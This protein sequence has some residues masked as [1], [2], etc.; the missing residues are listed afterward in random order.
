MQKGL[1]SEVF[2]SQE[3]FRA[4]LIAMANPGTI[5]RPDIELNTPG[6]IHKAAGA[7][8]LTL[9]DFET[10]F[11]FDLDKDA[12]DI[13]WIRFHTGA[14]YTFSPKNALFALITDQET[15]NKPAK[16]NPGTI[17]DPHESTTLI[18]QTRGIDTKGGM[19]LTGPGIERESFVRL[20]GINQE[21]L[22]QRSEV[23]HEYPFGIDMIFVW[24]DTF[25]AIPRTSHLEIL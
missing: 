4:L 2:D 10:P 11:W 5:I 15:Q 16:F 25:L 17:E 20:N 8:L 3:V 14:P 24:E 23:V 9:L 22:H 6:A 18:I 21:L 1:T 13:K 19:R 12:E 7:I